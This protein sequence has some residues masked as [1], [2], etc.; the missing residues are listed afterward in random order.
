MSNGHLITWEH[1]I[2]E[3]IFLKTA[4]NNLFHLKYNTTKNII[5]NIQKPASGSLKITLISLEAI[6]TSVTDL[7]VCK[8]IQVSSY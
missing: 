8:L 6:N 1:H 2:I 4:H 5:E 7:L 3:Y